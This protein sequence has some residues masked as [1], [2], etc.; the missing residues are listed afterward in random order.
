MSR[1]T[2]ARRKK[3]EVEFVK[4]AGRGLVIMSEKD[5]EALLDEIDAADAERIANDESDRILT[6]DE[7]KD[8]FMRN[9]IA[10]VRKE[11]GM[12]QKELAK[13]LR[14]KQSTV[15]RIE[16]NDANLTL[17]TLRRVAKALKRPVHELLY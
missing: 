6:W 2:A 5:Y 3:V 10:E 9:R 12:T 15:S 8:E 11:L 4:V 17:A 13:K 16:R 14:V 7:I 1:A